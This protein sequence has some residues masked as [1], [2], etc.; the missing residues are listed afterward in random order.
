MRELTLTGRNYA[1]VLDD[2]AYAVFMQNWQEGYGADGDHLKKK[3]DIRHALDLGYTMITLDC[4]EQ[5]DGN[6]AGLAAPAREQQTRTLLGPDYD[7]ALQRYTKA[8][9]PAHRP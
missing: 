6:A 3:E 8:G 7:A 9:P 1:G 2:A 4:S 5:I